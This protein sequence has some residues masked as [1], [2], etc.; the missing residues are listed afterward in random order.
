MLHARLSEIA[1]SLLLGIASR[2]FRARGAFA[3]HYRHILIGF[4]N[5]NFT[6]G[7]SHDHP[8]REPSDA[9]GKSGR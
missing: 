1:V 4:L 6:R 9:R 7:N 5:N 3:A 8:R 2:Y